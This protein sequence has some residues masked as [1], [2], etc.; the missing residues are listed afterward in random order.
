MREKLREMD[1]KDKA[2]LAVIAALLIITICAAAV[3]MLRHQKDLTADEL[4]EQLKDTAWSRKTEEG[5]EGRMFTMFGEMLIATLQDDGT[6]TKDSCWLT[7][8]ITGPHTLYLTNHHDDTFKRHTKF[9]GE[10]KISM[11]N[12]DTIEI[13]GVRYKEANFDKWKNIGYDETYWM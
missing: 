10:H 9:A 3:P 5:T 6:L 8:E 2:K 7:Y 12:D 4:R 13:D 1:G 11:I